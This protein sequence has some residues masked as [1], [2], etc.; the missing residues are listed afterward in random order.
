MSAYSINTIAAVLNAEFLLQ[1]GN[2]QIEHLCIDSRRIVHPASSLFFALH[3]ER[4]DGHSFIKQCYEKGVRNFI[5]AKTTDVHLLKD[6]NVLLV[7]DTLKALQQLAAYHRT[8]FHIPVIGITGSNG[9]TIVKEWLYQLLGDDFII[10]RSPK[11]YNSQVGVPLSVWQ[12]NSHHTLGIFEAGI[13]QTGEMQNLQ[14]II[15]PT[16][17]VFTCL[18]DA[19]N[20]GFSNADEKLKEKSLL[21]QAA[22][23]I[24]CPAKW[25]AA[26]KKNTGK[27]IINWGTDDSCI[28]QLL[29]TEKKNTFTSISFNR[30]GNSMDARLPFTDDA[31]VHNALTCIAVCLHLQ[32]PF[33]KLKQ[34]LLL[35]KP[36]SLRLELKKGIHHCTLIND[37]YSAD[38]SSFE[39][40]LNFLMQQ[41][42][43]RNKTIILSDFAVTHEQ[44]E[45]TYS[46]ISH[47][48]NSHAVSKLVSVGAV[49]QHYFKQQLSPQI[50]Y[51]SFSN[52]D[53][54]IHHLPSLALNNE[55]ILIK[56]ARSFGLEQLMSLLE[57]QVHQTVLE[58]NLS[59]IAANIKTIRRQLNPGVKLMAMVKAFS[60]GSGSYEIANLLQYHGADYLAVAFADEGVELRKAGITLPI[61]VMNPEAV[62][63]DALVDFNLEPE[64]Y[65][66]EITKAFAAFLEKE[67]LT[68]YPVHIKIDTGM[69]RLGFMQQELPVLIE[70]IK[71]EN[72]FSVQ[73]VF[74]HLAAAED[75]GEDAF[76][77]QQAKLFDDAC[78]LIKQH[79]NDSFLKHITNTSGILRYKSLQYDM[80]RVG[81]G[82][83]GI[84]SPATGTEEALSLK[85][86][87]AQLKQLEPGETVGYNRRGIITKPSVIATVRIGYA[88]GYPRNLS[89]GT[90]Y[91][92]IH[93]RPAP[94]TGTV[95]MDMTMLDVT[96]IP[97]V[98]E[99]DEVLVFGPQLSISQIAK[100]A[101]TIPYEIMSGISQR[102]KRVYF[103]E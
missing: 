64:L 3:T 59:A 101:G 95:C 34:K 10:A 62:T 9:K 27:E 88:D 7:Q 90:G 14:S 93:G 26:L 76:T 46:S 74:S 20:E 69:H 51:S 58:I 25:S 21:F 79:T 92:L 72:Y 42:Q 63:F 17:G 16:I 66:P 68:N 57:Q 19:H 52:I 31:S 22:S 24:I 50:I 98:K 91:M 102:V 48:I 44:E 35:L 5:V 37:S 47:L 103:E 85:T 53:E 80:V 8:Q 87:I 56:G 73:S 83:F 4:R 30:N 15:E 6:V 33:E 75:A 43:R 49:A 28:L 86:T 32:I 11:S 1:S 18:G 40:A 29:K 100:W 99:G 84:V 36:V 82:M 60:Y 54:L 23:V 2:S 78:A 13:S 94:V 38:L 97:H 70:I 39:I 12:L 89:N 81:I 65:S 96:D 61:M 41:K 71:K 55:A 67:G 77:Q 45:A